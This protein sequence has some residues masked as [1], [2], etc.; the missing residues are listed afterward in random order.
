M[1]GA[2]GPVVGWPVVV[3]SLPVSSGDNLI[4]TGSL[5][6][7]VPSELMRYCETAGLT[8]LLRLTRPP[9]SVEL[10]YERGELAEVRVGGAG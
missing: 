1:V 7:H 9:Q 3:I 5:A 8:G 2:P 10:F 6:V 4:K